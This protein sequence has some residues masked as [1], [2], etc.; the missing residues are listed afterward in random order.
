[1]TQRLDPPGRARTKRGANEAPR[2][3]DQ[4]IFPRIKFSRNIELT[5]GSNRYSAT[6]YDIS[7]GGL[8]F[9]ASDTVETG[10]ATIRIS[11]AYIFQGKILAQHNAGKPGVSRYHFQF[12]NSLELPTLA[13]ILGS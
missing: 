12:T 11:D 8:S 9:I 2:A 3:A 5:I 10:Q 13:G 7:Q 1:M 4:R 6:T